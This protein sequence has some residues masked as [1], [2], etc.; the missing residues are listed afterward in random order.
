MRGTAQPYPYAQWPRASRAEVALLRRAA[1]ALPVRSDERALAALEE[2]LGARA[3]GESGPLELCPAGEVS[4]CVA[5]PLV[6]LVVAPPGGR[7]RRAIAIELEPRLAVH[8]IDRALGGEGGS[9]ITPPVTPLR[10]GERGVLAYVAARVLAAAAPGWQLLAIVTTSASLDAALGGGAC[11]VWP[12]TMRLG[13]ELFAVRA[14]LPTRWLE[15]AADAT[16][17]AASAALSRIPIALVADAGSAELREAEIAS[18]RAGD[19]V[20]LDRATV[21]IGA[22]G[23]TGE[24][25]MRVERASRTTWWCRIEGGALRVREAERSRE[26]AR[27]EG[28]R[29]VDSDTK[30][31]EGIDHAGD[32]PIEVVVELARFTLPLEELASLRAGEILTTGRPIGERVTLRA[33]GRAIATGELVDVDGEMGVRILRLAQ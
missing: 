12:A 7:P 1:R 19:V 15:D 29:M 11:V 21:A 23:C 31:N 20:V 32:A 27:T 17:R 10:D 14:W 25:R 5:D 9:E 30:T 13:D 33:A 22:S 4:L 16:T 24:A 8:A 3:L 18:L 28:R 2:L 26:P 6:A